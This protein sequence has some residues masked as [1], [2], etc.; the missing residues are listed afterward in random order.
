MSFF[1]RFPYSN[2]HDLN[3][4]WI[5]DKINNMKEA[6][7]EALAE[8]L[9]TGL[10]GDSFLWSTMDNTLIIRDAQ[11]NELYRIT[12][13]SAGITL[14]LSGG[15][16]PLTYNVTAGKLTIPLLET[17]GSAALDSLSL[18]S[19]L[20][21]GSGGTGANS[22]SGARSNL[23]AVN[24]NGDTMTG[25]LQF[26]TGGYPT[27]GML[28][29]DN[30]RGI[31]IQPNIS[32]DARMQLYQYNAAG[33]NYE[34]YDLPALDAGLN[35]NNGYD[36]LTSK[37]TVVTPSPGGH[38]IT[39]AGGYIRLGKVIVLDMTVVIDTSISQYSI[40]ADDLPLSVSNPVFPGVDSSYT[41]KVFKLDSGKI[42]CVGGCAAGTYYINGSYIAQ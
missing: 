28:R 8:I 1:R 41:T 30:S 18:T 40:V 10:D 25:N 5:I 3:L 11:D 4:D 31:W 39:T 14:T 20:P 37:Q 17:T 19:P 29:N 24:I 15:M 36:I 7:A 13:D 9:A 26:K 21:I 2:A 38:A 34:R 32:G 22:A 12:I 33:T 6:S 23:G 27:I 35:T 16:T 42:Y